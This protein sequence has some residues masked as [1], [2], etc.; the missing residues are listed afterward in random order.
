[1]EDV[2]CDIAEVQK[3]TFGPISTYTHK[4]NESGL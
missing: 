3:L 1:M 2:I 4:N